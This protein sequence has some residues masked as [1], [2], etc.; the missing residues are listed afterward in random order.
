MSGKRSG[1]GVNYAYLEANAARAKYRPTAVVVGRGPVHL[2]ENPIGKHTITLGVVRGPDGRVRDIVSPRG[3]AVRRRRGSFGPSLSDAG[4]GQSNMAFSHPGVKRTT[5]PF[6][7]GLSM[8]GQAAMAKW[9][10]T[11]ASESLRVKGF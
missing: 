4:F 5:G 2:L 1:P 11:F 6:R 7:R 8:S 3:N 9:Q 10:S